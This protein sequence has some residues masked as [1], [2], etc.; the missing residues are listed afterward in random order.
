MFVL[1][2]FCGQYSPRVTFKMAET[3]S[4]GV[5]NAVMYFNSLTRNN[6]R[7]VKSEFVPRGKLSAIKNLNPEC[8]KVNNSGD[9][10]SAKPQVNR[11][12]KRVDASLIQ[13]LENSMSSPYG[14]SSIDGKAIK[15]KPDIVPRSL[16]PTKAALGLEAEKILHDFESE[17]SPYSTFIISKEAAN[18]NVVKETLELIPRLEKSLRKRSSR[19]R[20]T[21]KLSHR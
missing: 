7:K 9:S 13:N 6:G 17:I 18:S 5:K 19:T 2:G 16:K 21:R 1:F 14:R 15:N 11:E 12:I 3:S 10:E 4:P 20:N 8:V